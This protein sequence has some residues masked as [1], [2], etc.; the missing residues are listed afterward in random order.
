MT[1]SNITDG[2]V[3]FNFNGTIDVAIPA[4]Y[5]DPKFKLLSFFNFAK[6]WYIHTGEGRAKFPNGQN[7]NAE[8]D[9]D[10]SATWRDI[11]T[12]FSS[13]IPEAERPNLFLVNIVR[14]II[15]ELPLDNITYTQGQCTELPSLCVIDT[16]L[17]NLSTDSK[18]NDIS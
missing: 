1:N 11:F 13:Y 16:N 14:R 12:Q 2:L 6:T 7:P 10:N 17:E 8:I 18:L 4:Y 5:L 15:G 9:P 3:N